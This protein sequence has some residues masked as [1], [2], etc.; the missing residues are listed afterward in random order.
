M[1][2]TTSLRI[3]TSVWAR[4]TPQPSPRM[5][6]ALRSPTA[7]N[8][9]MPSSFPAWPTPQWLKTLVAK[10]RGATPDVV[11]T[12]STPSC[13]APAASTSVAS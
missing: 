2:A 7:T 10:V 1:W 12:T 3:T 5:I 11:R 4:V 8:S 13:P 6:S 9:R